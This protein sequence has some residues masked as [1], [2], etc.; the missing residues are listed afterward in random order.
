MGA[1]DRSEVMQETA[2]SEFQYFDLPDAATHIRLL[3]IIAA[4]EDNDVQCGLS[5]WSLESAPPYNA[6]SY[7][8]GARTETKTIQLNG[9]RLVVRSNCE[10]VLRQT[11]LYDHN[12]YIWI[13]ALCIDQGN[14]PEN[15]VQVAMMGDLYKR[16]ERVLAC[17]GQH[18]DDSEYFM[19]V[20]YDNA[21][22]Y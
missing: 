5:V 15:N 11:Y 10:Y 20:L 21:Q 17:I 9:H 16:A 13:D 8:W 14:V 22:L 3:R 6:I 2:H 7:T 12:M 18:A 19:R 4:E 1:S